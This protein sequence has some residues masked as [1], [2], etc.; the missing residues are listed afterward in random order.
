MRYALVVIFRW[1]QIRSWSSK[2]YVQIFTR[3]MR[4]VKLHTSWNAVLAWMRHKS[5]NNQSIDQINIFTRTWARTYGL[6]TMTS[7]A[8]A[9]LMATLNLFGL[10][11][12]PRVCFLSN[13]IILSLARTLKEI[14]KNSPWVQLIYYDEWLIKECNRKH[15]FF[16]YIYII[17]LIWWWPSSADLEILLLTRPWPSPFQACQ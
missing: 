12:K 5:I 7:R 1:H 2:F 8:W 10:L 17:P 6:P 11:R 4:R 15:F 13:P 14:M 3:R 9:L 16:F